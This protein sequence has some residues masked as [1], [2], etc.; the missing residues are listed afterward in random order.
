MFI[1][2]GSCLFSA[3]AHRSPIGPVAALPL[4]H[5]CRQLSSRSETTPPPGIAMV[6]RDR[7]GQ[8]LWIDPD[9]VSSS[10]AAAIAFFGRLSFQPRLPLEAAACSSHHMG[11][12]HATETSHHSLN[13]GPDKHVGCRWYRGPQPMACSTRVGRRV[14]SYVRFLALSMRTTLSKGSSVSLCRSFGLLAG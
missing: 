11:H 1:G 13:R 10:E 4:C 2:D 12:L 14:S 7:N 5:R 3:G 8:R 9:G 6:F